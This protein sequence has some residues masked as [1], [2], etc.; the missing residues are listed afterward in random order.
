MVEDGGGQ[1]LEGGG[2]AESPAP[3]D[4]G[5]GVDIE[6]PER[7]GQLGEFLGQ[8]PDQGHRTAGLLLVDAQIIQ[9]DGGHA[10]VAGFDADGMGVVGCDAGDGIQIDAGGQ[11]AAQLVVRVTAPQLRPSG[12]GEEQRFAVGAAG[13]DLGKLL[14]QLQQPGLRRRRFPAVDMLQLFPRRAGAQIFQ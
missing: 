10:V 2:G 11:T 5:G 6:A 4:G 14:R 12:R 1:H 9:V 8:T 13:E 3:Q 7:S